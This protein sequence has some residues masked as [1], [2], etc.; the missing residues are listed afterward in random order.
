MLKVCLGLGLLT[1][2]HFRLDKWL[3]NA[4]IQIFLIASEAASL[5]PP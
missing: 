3:Y 2:G 5:I 1:F 4:K